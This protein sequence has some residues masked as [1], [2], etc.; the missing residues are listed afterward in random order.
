MIEIEIRNKVAKLKNPQHN[1]VCDNSDYVVRFDFDAEWDAF[2]HK[3]ARFA[4]NGNYT[5]VLFEGDTVEMPVISNA[6]A[7]LIGVYAGNLHTTTA[8]VVFLDQ[9]IL[10]GNGTPVDPTPSV[11]EQLV[12]ALDS[13]YELPDGGIPKSDLTESVQG[14][15]EKADSALQRADLDGYATESW[16]E[17]KGYLTEHQSLA[18]YRTSAEQDAIDA[19]KADAD[20]VYGRDYLDGKFAEKADADAVYDKTEVNTAL[21][22]KA[23]KT[24]LAETDDSLKAL[25][26][27]NRGQTYLVE[28]DT[29]NAYSKQIKS[30]VIS[31]ANKALLNSIGGRSVVE[32]QLFNAF[33][34]GEGW[35]KTPSHQATFSQGVCTY[36]VPSSA[37]SGTHLNLYER[38]YIPNGHKFFVSFDVNPDHAQTFT[39]YKFDAPQMIA[40]KALSAGTYSTISGIGT[41]DIAAGNT[42]RFMLYMANSQGFLGYELTVLVKNPRLVDLTQWFGSGSEPSSVDDPKMAEVYAYLEAHPEYNRGSIK[43]A[44]VNEVVVKDADDVVIKTETIPQAIRELEGYGESHESAVNVVDYSEKTFR[45]KGYYSSGEWITDERNIDISDHIPDGFLS[46]MPVESG[47]SITFKQTDSELQIPN[48]ISYLRKASEVG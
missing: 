27:F 12:E 43:S 10:R 36:T 8:E 18:A 45:K 33:A 28:T 37:Q 13:K 42:A 47:G 22:L 1:I 23:D 31:E 41:S 25:W 32:N 30:G 24:A 20:D 14:S 19:T 26:A 46:N 35:Q 48:S 4:Y 3:T 38:K 11:Y 6:T 39:I 21:A 40:S 29:A 15:L 34:D 7:V 9:S 17:A 44:D 16:V 5:D 2:D